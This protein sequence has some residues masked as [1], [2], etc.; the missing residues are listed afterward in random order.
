MDKPLP[1]PLDIDIELSWNETSCVIRYL[2]MKKGGGSKPKY[3]ARMHIIK[4]GEDISGWVRFDEES[5]WNIFW[6]GS[7]GTSLD[8]RVDPGDKVLFSEPADG[9]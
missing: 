2:E 5:L 3:N 8:L 4:K 9:K 7:R 6:K 1:R